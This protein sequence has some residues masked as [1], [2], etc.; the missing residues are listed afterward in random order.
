MADFTSKFWSLFIIVGVV[1]GILAMFWLN[2]WMS[3]GPR[4]PEG[5]KAKPTGHKWDED[6]QELN[7]PLPKW[8]LNLFYLTLVFS[9]LYLALYPGLGSFAGVLGW[10]SVGQYHKEQNTAKA[11]YDPLY[12]QYL[13]QDLKT[14]AV[15]AGAVRTGERL[16]ATYCTT[17]HGADARGGS[18]FPNLRDKDWLYGGELE[19]IKATIRDGRQGTM[20]AWEAVL[21]VE[22]V[23]NV[24]EY[25]LSLSGRRVNADAADRGKEKYKELCASCHGANAQGNVAMGAPNLTDDVW[26]HGASQKAV[27]QSISKGRSGRMPAHGEF[28]GEAKVH[29]LAAY[30]Y[31]LSHPLE[32]DRVERPRP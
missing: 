22:G 18:G 10:T 19:Q 27:M 3:K 4:L 23:F 31:S 16:F 13:K 20:P 8:W 17:C 32:P 9:I 6:L 5:D 1:G 25:V 24:S 30:V 7:N 26:L 29:L 15:N 11:L 2:R 12:D 28:L 21:G 14:L